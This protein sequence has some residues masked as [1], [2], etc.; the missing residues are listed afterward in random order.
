MGSHHPRMPDDA[1]GIGARLPIEQSAEVASTMLWA[2][3]RVGAGLEAATIFVAD[4]QSGGY[5]RLGRQWHSPVG[6]LWMTAAFPAPRDRWGGTLAIRAG[7]ACLK[8]IQSV[9]GSDFAVVLKWPND[10]LV[11][12]RKVCGILCESFEALGKPWTLIGIGINVNNNPEDLPKDLRRPPTSLAHLSS[13]VLDIGE[14][15]DQLAAE[16]LAALK[17]ESAR[18]IIGF[19]APRLWSV[20]QEIGIRLGAAETQRGILRGLSDEGLLVIETDGRRRTAPLNAEI[21]FE[22]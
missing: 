11:V 18:E 15:R 1:F 5:G 8:L 4:R 6:G 10:I 2:R 9:L 13:R 7:G 3:E 22:P 12:D 14:L 21:L 17:P 16:L 20:D 19:I